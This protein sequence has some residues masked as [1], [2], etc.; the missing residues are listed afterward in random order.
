MGHTVWF[1][2]EEKRSKLNS[3]DDHSIME[4]LC[5]D[6]DKLCKKLKVKKLTEYFDYSE[7]AAEYAEVDEELEP[8]WHDP[9]AGLSTISALLDH[10]AKDPKK[11]AFKDESKSH[12]R[13]M[14]LKELQDCRRRLEKAAAEEVRFNLKV[15]P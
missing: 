14:L 7:L 8:D 9:A 2:V 1:R 15:V 5:D 6:L 3:D 11:F 13:G 10:L 4:K 12:W